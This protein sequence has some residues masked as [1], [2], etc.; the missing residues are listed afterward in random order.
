MTKSDTLLY[1]SRLV[2]EGA[3]IMRSAKRMFLAEVVSLSLALVVLVFKL[4]TTPWPPASSEA[5]P[6]VVGLVSAVA[7]VCLG[8]GA[9]KAGDARA[10][11]AMAKLADAQSALH[12]VMWHARRDAGPVWVFGESDG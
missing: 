4:S 8:I 3:M 6:L 2:D 10:A 11:M 5:L 7:L 12:E 9:R 1:A